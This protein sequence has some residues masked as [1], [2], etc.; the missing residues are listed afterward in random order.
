MLVAMTVIAA[1]FWY[2]ISWLNERRHLLADGS[3]SDF[4]DG[5]ISAPTPLQYFGESGCKKL[6]VTAEL[7]HSESERERLRTLFPEAE[8][9][10]GTRWTS[11]API[12]EEFPFIQRLGRKT[13]FQ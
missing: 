5:P 10:S 9:R 7:W 2:H 3:L 6:W 8:F 12:T 13:I 11:L 1:F 4:S